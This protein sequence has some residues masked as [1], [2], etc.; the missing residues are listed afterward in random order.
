M[1][2]IESEREAGKT[3]ENTAMDRKSGFL[4]SIKGA[5]RSLQD[6]LEPEI[7]SGAKSTAVTPAGG[8]NATTEATVPE[9]EPEKA[10]EK[11]KALDRIEHESEPE[12]AEIGTTRKSRLFTLLEDS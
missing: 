7:E 3:I 11:D 9:S 10:A 4:L 12:K 5:N 2:G 1:E 6:E 8:E